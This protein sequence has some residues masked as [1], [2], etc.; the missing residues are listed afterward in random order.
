MICE[1]LLF[2]AKM[3]DE[4]A[5]EQVLEMYQPLLVKNALVN[6]VFDEDLYQELMLETLKCIR[7]FRKLE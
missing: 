7:N 5:V 6:G 1:E 2:Q 4:K 3:G